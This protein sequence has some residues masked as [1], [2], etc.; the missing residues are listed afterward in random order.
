MEGSFS[1][2]LSQHAIA[3]DSNSVLYLEISAS[4]V[5]GKT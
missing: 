2:F 1:T 4:V 5:E 3:Q